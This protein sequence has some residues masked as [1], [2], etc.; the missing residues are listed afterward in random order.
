MRKPIWFL[1]THSV[2]L[3]MRKTK[4]N[5]ERFRTIQVPYYLTIAAKS[6]ALQSDM[7]KSIKHQLGLS[8]WQIEILLEELNRLYA[9]PER[10]RWVLQTGRRNA[11][12]VV[13]E[14]LLNGYLV[15][16]SRETKL[17]DFI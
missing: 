15:V 12:D 16:Q 17:A 2:P 5:V 6:Q 4:A 7:V 13:E 14:L 9:L 10:I 3:S 1:F 8:K 11:A